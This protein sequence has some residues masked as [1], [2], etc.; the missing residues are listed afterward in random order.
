LN[1]DEISPRSHLKIPELIDFSK[2]LNPVVIEMPNEESH[3][4]H[5]KNKK[6]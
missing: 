5:M 1:D 2:F 4:K 6:I 3:K